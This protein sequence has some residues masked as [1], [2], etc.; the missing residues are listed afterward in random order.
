MALLRKMT[1]KDK[2]SYDSTPPCSQLYSQFLYTKKL[3]HYSTTCT[4]QNDCR[5]HLKLQV[6]FAGNSL[7]YRALLQKRPIALSELY[8]HSVEY[9]QQHNERIPEN[10]RSLLQK[11]PIKSLSELFSK[12]I[13]HTC[14]LQNDCRAHYRAHFSKKN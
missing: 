4:L 7:F 8:S 11:S 14:I 1:C 2:A 12:D 13:N 10:Y 9:M 5:A 6:S 3:C